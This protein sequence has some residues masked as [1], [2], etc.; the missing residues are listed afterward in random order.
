MEKFLGQQLFRQEL[1]LKF[2]A[3]WQ[4]KRTLCFLVLSI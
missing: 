1:S 3:K 2:V 4:E